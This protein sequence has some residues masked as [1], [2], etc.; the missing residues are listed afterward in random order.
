MEIINLIISL[1]SGA[2]G[3]NIAGAAS[4]DKNLGPLINTI[5]GLFGGGFGA[6]IGKALGLFAATHV[7]GA[8]GGAGFDLSSLLANIG[9]SGVSGGVLTGVITLIKDAMQK[10]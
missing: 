9:I 8:D 7:P 5:A 1:I 2:A 3:G 6:F 4:T 10:R